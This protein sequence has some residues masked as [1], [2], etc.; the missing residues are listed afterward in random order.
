[1]LSFHSFGCVASAA[2][3]ASSSIQLLVRSSLLVVLL[4]LLSSPAPR[5]AAA[6]FSDLFNSD[7]NE[8]YSI[9]GWLHNYSL[10]ATYSATDPFSNIDSQLAF[11]IRNL[12]QSHIPDIAKENLSAIDSI[13]YNKLKPYIDPLAGA[14]GPGICLA[15]ISFLVGL[16]YLP[17]RLCVAF[18]NRKKPPKPI[19]PSASITTILMFILTVAWGAITV[20]GCALG[21]AANVQ[22]TYTLKNGWNTAD[23]A[24]DTVI[25][26]G[27]AVIV[28]VNDLPNN[29]SGIFSDV[30]GEV[31]DLVPRLQTRTITLLNKFENVT[32][33]IV[34]LDHKLQAIPAAQQP[35]PVTEAARQMAAKVNQTIAP[36]RELE[37][38]LNATNGTF[39]ALLNKDMSF[40]LNTSGINDTLNNVMDKVTTYTDYGKKYA[41]MAVGYDA[42][43]L[44]A[45]NVLFAMP[46]LSL[47]VVAA[48]GLLRQ[49]WLFHAVVILNFFVLFFSFAMG[50]VHLGLAI[51]LGEACHV[52][53]T[54]KVPK[55][56]LTVLND[57]SAPGR[58]SLMNVAGYNISKMI[59]D[60]NVTQQVDQFNNATVMGA[61]NTTEVNQFLDGAIKLGEN[62]TTGNATWVEYSAKVAKSDNA[63]FAGD[64]TNY[65]QET[66]NSVKTLINDFTDDMVNQ[67]EGLANCGFVPSTFYRLHQQ[68][69]VEMESAFDIMWL[70]CFMVGFFTIPS[71]VVESC[72]IKRFKEASALRKKRLLGDAGIAMSTD[73]AATLPVGQM[74]RNVV[75]P[76]PETDLTLA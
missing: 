38:Q 56:A 51:V 33:Q 55:L 50:S 2:T 14:V 4:L 1:M 46:I 68:L 67:I 7:S 34:L 17:I 70:G 71:I 47:I 25:N 29:I 52:V 41:K 69:C 65:F 44:A 3:A 64:L 63:G 26:R 16:I 27:N 66:I 57:C 40:S 32:E 13:N 59:D 35:Q 43:R 37:M 31:R 5:P 28:M 54:V 20:A 18:C 6:Q 12:F 74:S 22:F 24:I 9:E 72:L 8:S 62:D 42:Y 36:L 45:F 48:A 60:F 76:A 11:P 39:S 58:D 53:D 19:K 15:I 21:I 75:A 49:G 10:V 30:K 61:V 73:P 23:G